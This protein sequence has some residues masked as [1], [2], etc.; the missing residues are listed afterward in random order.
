LTYPIFKAIS[1]DDTLVKGATTHP[2]IVQVQ[3]N[4]GIEQFIIKLY[5][6][7]PR[8]FLTHSTVKEALVHALAVELD[9]SVPESAFITISDEFCDNLEINELNQLSKMVYLK[10]YGEVNSLRE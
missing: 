8:R 4:S 1:H 10:L 3:T 5:E 6:N 2:W 7:K 9:L